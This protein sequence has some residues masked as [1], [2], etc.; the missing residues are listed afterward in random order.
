MA[1]AT[2]AGLVAAAFA[3]ACGAPPGPLD[4][5][6]VDHGHLRRFPRAPEALAAEVAAVDGILD[7][8][9]GLGSRRYVLFTRDFEAL[10]T[11]DDVAAVGAQAGPILAPGRRAEVDRN[12]GALGAIASHAADRG[13]EL[14]VHTNQLDVPAEV[15]R[16]LG[17]SVGDQGRVCGDRPA[18]W[19]LYRGKM[20]SFFRDFPAVAGLVLTADEAPYPVWACDAP[21]WAGA[22][23]TPAPEV[24]AARVT[25]LVTET[26]AVAAAFDRRLEVRAWDRVEALAGAEP[27]ALPAGVRLSVKNTA[28]DFQLFAGPSALL[29]AGNGL[30]VEFDAWREYSGWNYF[31]CYMGDIW[32]PR[33]LA[34][35]EAGASTLALRINWSSTAN[36]IFER[37]WGNVVNVAVARGLA[38]RPDADPD[39]L[40]KAWIAAT[41]PPDAA[42]PAFRLY[43]ASPR[44]LETLTSVGRVETTD[45]GRLFRSRTS[46]S[47][48]DRVAD[49][50]DRAQAE[51]LLTGAADFEARRRRV[52]GAVAQARDLVAALPPSVRPEWRRE[53]ERGAAALGYLAAATTDQLALLDAKRRLDAGG[54]APGLAALALRMRTNDAAWRR[55]DAESYETLK[56]EEALSML[57]ACK[58]AK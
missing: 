33:V 48:F 10:L 52:D 55:A 21:E 35:A 30:V 51:G 23:A 9:A 26:A 44:I 3:A 20:E 43:K 8:A 12:R 45:H 27:G 1:T 25:R 47:V 40:L 53:M 54:R 19:R 18:T 5:A 46:A 41:Y 24:V 2:F 11:Y 42:G 49:S 38:A 4:L 36:P 37:P 17:D 56:G 32:A 50:L 34:A 58:C 29:G 39:D 22:G 15:R 28:G 13:L 7:R 6:L 14:M 57:R 16:R 31:P